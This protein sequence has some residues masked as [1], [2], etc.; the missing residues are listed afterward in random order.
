MVVSGAGTDHSRSRRCSRQTV[1][2]SESPRRLVATTLARA[3]PSHNST[4]PYHATLATLTEG[5]FPQ[6]PASLSLDTLPQLTCLANRGTLAHAIPVSAT[7]AIVR[8]AAKLFDDL[9]DGDIP[10]TPLHL[11]TASGTM[12]LLPL[13]L[14]PLFEQGVSETKFHAIAESLFTAILE[15]GAGQHQDLELSTAT[16][17][18]LTPTDWLAIA[19][20]KSGAL[21]RW[22]AWAGAY[23]S[24]TPTHAEAYGKYGELLGVLLQITDDY[25]DTWGHGNQDLASG[26][27]SL[28]ICYTAYVLRD[29]E[30]DVEALWQRAKRG[31]GTARASLLKLMDETGAFYFV[32]ET[33]TLHWNQISDTLNRTQ[34][35]P[36]VLSQLR[37][38]AAQF[39]TPFTK[40]V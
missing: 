12:A 8:L 22:A 26:S 5:I 3:L 31:D 32:Q 35:D 11:N 29:R 40:Q 21:L 6:N 36:L 33:A 39:Y 38:I 27:L 13:L 23:L 7:W 16:T 20:A 10:P 28:P 17:I 4:A 1:I 34:G 19:Y 24:D 37:N 14:Q 30:N 15:A 9:E 2:D 18:S 25:Y